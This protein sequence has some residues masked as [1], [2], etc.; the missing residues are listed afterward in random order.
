MLRKR[1]TLI[2][3]SSKGIL[4]VKHFFPRAWSLP[5]GGVGLRENFEKAARRELKEE[6]GLGV[7]K[8]RFLFDYNFGLHRHKVFLVEAKGNINKNWEIADYEFV[9]NFKNRKMSGFAKRILGKYLGGKG[10]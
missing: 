8:I 7:K 3:K 2:V 6:L 9:K 1:A 4:L 5:G 10:F